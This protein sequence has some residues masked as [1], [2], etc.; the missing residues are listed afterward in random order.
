MDPHIGWRQD[1]KQAIAD[2][3]A[4]YEANDGEESTAEDA[5]YKRLWATSDKICKTVAGTHQGLIAQLQHFLDHFGDE[6][7]NGH[8]TDWRLIENAIASL[9]TMEPAKMDQT[10]ESRMRSLTDDQLTW[11][12]QRLRED[13]LLANTDNIGPQS[14]RAD[15]VAARN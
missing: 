4:A 6:L 12:I 11:A 2:Y 8:N 10:L 3:V 7:G 14:Q 1:W 5:A 13:G 15:P 9:T